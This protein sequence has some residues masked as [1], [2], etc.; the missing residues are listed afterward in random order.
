[1]MGMAIHARTSTAGRDSLSNR[2]GAGVHPPGSRRSTR[3]VAAPPPQ[4][5]TSPTIQITIDSGYRGT[6]PK[7]RAA[8]RAQTTMR[9]YGTAR[10]V[11]GVSHA[12]NS[13][14]SSRQRMPTSAPK[15]AT[16]NH[17][18]VG[19]PRTAHPALPDRCGHP[20]PHAR[21]DQPL[22]VRG[23]DRAPRHATEHRQ[24]HAAHGSPRQQLVRQAY[25]CG[26]RY[27]QEHRTEQ[28]HADTTDLREHATREQK[29]RR[30]V[31]HHPRRPGGSRSHQPKPGHRPP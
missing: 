12:L 16:I 28:S 21:H 5:A 26:D 14:R 18:M 23:H 20:D 25:R 8:S 6:K 7:L 19:V 13:F 1:M 10:I 27:G 22:L 31:G 11:V 30:G 24:Y 2:A 17:A 9:K 4:K 29:Q 3:A 15:A